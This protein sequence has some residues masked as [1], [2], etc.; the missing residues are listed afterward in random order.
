MLFL[1][2]WQFGSSTVLD[3]LTF[4]DTAIIIS[5][6]FLPVLILFIQMQFPYFL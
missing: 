1:L 2:Y 6:E 5:A 4:S 3:V